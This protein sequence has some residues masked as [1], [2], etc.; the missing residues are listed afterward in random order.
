MVHYKH[1]NRLLTLFELEPQFPLN[2]L[3]KRRSGRG[4]G[5]ELAVVGNIGNSA[6]TSSQAEEV[7]KTICAVHWGA[8]TIMDLSTGKH[9]HE[10]RKWILRN[11]LYPSVPFSSTRRIE[12]VGCRVISIGVDHSG[13]HL[14]YVKSINRSP[15]YGSSPVGPADRARKPTAGKLANDG[16]GEVFSGNFTRLG[17]YSLK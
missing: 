10:T 1:L 16:L 9:I 15:S 13:A 5:F 7:E 4:V 8:D 11:A 2:R 6:V 3:R 12:K 17:P 14:G